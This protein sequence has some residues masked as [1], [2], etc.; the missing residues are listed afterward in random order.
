MS[1]LPN[2]PTAAMNDP[3]VRA[4]FAEFGAE[5]MATTPEELGRFIS[6]E[7]SKWRAIITKAGITIDP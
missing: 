7:V 5:P 3:A 4:R 2:V 1:A 6:A